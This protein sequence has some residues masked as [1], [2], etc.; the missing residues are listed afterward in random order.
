M[1][2]RRI[3]SEAWW[4][5]WHH[6]EEQHDPIYDQV[7]VACENHHLKILMG[8]HSDW[9]VEVIA[10]FYTTLYIEE[11]GGARKM[12]WMSED[13]WYN[14]SYEDFASRLSFGAADAHRPRLH[15]HNTLDED[16]MKFMYALRQEENA[17]TI[18]RLYTFY[19]VLNILFRKTICPR[20]GDPTNISQFAKNLLANMR[21]G[22]PPLS[23]M[24]FYV[25]IDKGHLYEPLKDLW[26]CTLSYVHDWG[27]HK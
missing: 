15:I 17:G 11:G 13:D 10:Q 24:D 3:V 5:D 26:L 12:H 23:M 2:R 6:M 14:I 21:Y 27:C 25:G 16:E 1:D 9:N 20:D 22:A 4:V 18:N 7:I 19:S 8:A